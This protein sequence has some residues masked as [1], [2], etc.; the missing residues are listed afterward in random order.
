VLLLDVR[1]S[2][3]VPGAFG[4]IAGHSGIEFSVLMCPELAALDVCV[5][6]CSFPDT[7]RSKPSQAKQIVNWGTSTYA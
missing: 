7:C 6:S 1:M 5:A 3:G 4:F 2:G